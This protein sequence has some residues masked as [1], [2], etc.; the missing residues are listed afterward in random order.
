MRTR[1]LLILILLACACNAD[2]RPED[3][4]MPDFESVGINEGVQGEVTFVCRM[5]SMQQITGCGLYYAEAGDAAGD[6]LIKVPGVKSGEDSF[7]V[8]LQG[9][10]P[11]ATYT[12]CFY[13]SNGRKEEKSPQNH[14]TVPE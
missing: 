12:Y 2:P 8:S 13:I 10:A 4:L 6:N 5:S 9:L 1:I 7:S 11:G 3:F 14:Y